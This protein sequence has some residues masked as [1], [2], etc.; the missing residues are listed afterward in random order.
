[1]SILL[2]VTLLAAST[3]VAIWLNDRLPVPELSE[4]ELGI[5][6]QPDSVQ[7]HH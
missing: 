7:A 3:S 5:T 6:P 2:G 1:M 4:E